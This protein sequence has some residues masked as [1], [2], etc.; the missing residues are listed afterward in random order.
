VAAVDG[1][2]G[3]LVQLPGAIKQGRVGVARL[4]RLRGLQRRLDQVLEPLPTM[5]AMAARG[6]GARPSWRS[7]AASAI[8]KSPSVSTSV[9]SRSSTQARGDVLI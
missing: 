3:V 2:V 5:Q 1:P 6:S 9:P 7:M 8:S 4:R